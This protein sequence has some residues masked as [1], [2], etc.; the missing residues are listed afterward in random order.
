MKKRFLT[1]W[2]MLM[3]ITTPIWSQQ[4]KYVFYFIGDGM[5]VNQTLLFD[6]LDDVSGYSDGENQFY[7]YMLPYMGYSRTD[8]LSGTTDSAAGGTAL[9]TGY[10]TTNGSVGRDKD[11]EDLLLFTEFCASLGM[12]TAVMSTENRTGATPSSFSAHA[13]S[14]ND[15]SDILDSQYLLEANC[16]TVIDCGYDYYTKNYMKV[17]DRHINETLGKISTDE[18]GF[19]LMY[20]EGYIDK[21]GTLTDKYYEDKSG[22]MLRYPKYC[23]DKVE[24][25]ARPFSTKL[26]IIRIGWLNTGCYFDLEDEN[27]KVYSMNDVMFSNYIT[28]KNLY[29]E[30]D[31]DFYKQGIAYSIGLQ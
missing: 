8:S 19:F 21:Q 17:I 6:Y 18:D 23:N 10:K 31:F 15:S 11:G 7:G 5:G 29:I 27:G 1:A 4:A 3:A 9:S 28:N 20:E 2:I 13:A 16:G 30:G 25:E 12:S 24:V 26:R 14:R 22:K